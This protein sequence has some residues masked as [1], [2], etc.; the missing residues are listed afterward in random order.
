MTIPSASI[1]QT[2]VDRLSK[3]PPFDQLEAQ[4][5]TRLA[6]ST[7]LTYIEPGEA[8][9]QQGQPSNPEAY[10]IY[11]GA[12]DI[13][14]TRS[15]T[16]QLIHICEVG[17]M[18][19]VRAI[20]AKREYLCTATAREPTLL[21]IIPSTVLLDLIQ[22]SSSIALFFAANFAGEPTTETVDRM[23]AVHEAMRMRT[24]LS[25]VEETQPVPFSKEIVVSCPPTTSIRVAAQMM[26]SHRVGSIVVVDANHHPVGILTDTDLRSRVVATGYDPHQS[27][28]TVMSHPVRS[29]AQDTPQAMVLAEMIRKGVHHFPVTEDGTSNSP[30]IGVIAERDV[31]RAQEPQPTVILRELSR[32]QAQDLNPLLNEA[33]SILRRYLASETSMDFVSQVISEINNTLV[34]RCI[35]LALSDMKVSELPTPFC[36]L[37][38]GSEARE[39][40]LLRTDQDN[41]LVYADG[42]DSA[43]FLELGE[44]TVN[45]ITEAGFHRCP[46]GVM[47]SQ[48]NWNRSLTEWKQQITAWLRAPD[49]TSAMHTHICLDL[50]PVSHASDIAKALKQHVLNQVQQQRGLLTFLAKQTVDSPPPLGF[51][52]SEVIER[53]G[54]HRSLF[55]IKARA[56]APLANAAR[57][58]A[59]ELGLHQ[60]FST[61]ERWR[62]IADADPGLNRLG[63]EA[64]LSYLIL[65]RIRASEGLAQA[66]DGRYIRIKSLNTIER[67]T[68]RSTFKVVEDVRLMMV[69]RF[70][71]NLVR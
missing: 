58:L 53:S 59:Y 17:E 64:A 15:E 7:H 24:Q 65:M 49:P 45:Y 35:H 50:R 23:K 48:S 40:Q 20:V 31:L 2:A 27:V 51:F 12:I 4:E 9:F 11:K 34:R 44:R 37:A 56:M 42:G 14:R 55:D 41:A 61:P 67:Q 36:W 1:I 68:L 69:S 47:A 6:K 46:G 5:L 8:V 32:A 22:S 33:E 62:A 10:L 57:V 30:L 16:A 70:H 21:Y 18:F 63:K 60:A 29:L 3:H 13:H 54:E 71:L 19:G 38:L 26:S 28:D 39:E 43:F 52:R 25:L 66:S